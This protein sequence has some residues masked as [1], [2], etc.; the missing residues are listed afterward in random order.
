[1]NRGLFTKLI[2]VALVGAAMLPLGRWL[3]PHVSEAVTGGQF[4]AIEAVLGAS[5]GFGLSSLVG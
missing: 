2:C 1:M 4:E 5:I 3:Y